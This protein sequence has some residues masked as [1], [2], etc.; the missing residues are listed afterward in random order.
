[1]TTQLFNFGK[2]TVRVVIKDG[3]PWFVLKD[4]CN[5]LGVE[6]VAGVVRR[7]EEDVISKHP[8]QTSG[9]RQNVT[10]VSEEGLYDV[11]FDSHKPAARKFRKWV[12]GDVLPSIRKH[13]VYAADELLDNPD[14]FIETLQRLKAE[15]ERNKELQ[16]VIDTQEPYVSFAL[17]IT[18][19]EGSMSVG[20]AAKWI[21]ELGHVIGPIQLFKKLRDWEMVGKKSIFNIPT[22]RAINLGYLE[23]AT[24]NRP[25]DSLPPNYQTMVTRRGLEYIFRRLLKE[26]SN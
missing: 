1:M 15:K 9:G 26:R 3:Q 18:E 14:L 20:E 11:V 19:S 13:G 5:A 8:L 4:V 2:Q 22:Q 16:A 21:S 23:L 25:M 6:Q 7:L 17:A 12:T 24:R 10:V